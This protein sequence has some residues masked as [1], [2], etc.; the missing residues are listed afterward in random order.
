MWRG[1]LKKNVF[2]LIEL[3]V[4][5][6]II[7]ILFSLLLPSLS[8]AKQYAKKTQCASNLKGIGLA[9]SC[10]AGDYKDWLPP[11]DANIWCCYDINGVQSSVYNFFTVMKSYL[12]NDKA[13]RNYAPWGKIFYCPL[14]TRGSLFSNS[15]RFDGDARISYFYQFQNPPAWARPR[16]ARKIYTTQPPSY[17]GFSYPNY[18]IAQDMTMKP[19]ASGTASGHLDVSWIGTGYPDPKDNGNF[20]YVDGSVRLIT[21]GQPGFVSTSYGE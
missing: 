1:I 21:R 14:M 12:T 3:L 13:N 4:V 8:K 5:V 7:A 15:F 16:G 18:R 11:Y 19:A 9:V 17:A 2:T 10:Y 20:L 6:A